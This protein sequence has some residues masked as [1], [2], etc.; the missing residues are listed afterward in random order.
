[1][2]M[3]VTRINH[4][5]AKKKTVEQLQAFME[6][7]VSKVQTLPGC[8]SVKLLRSTENPAHFAIVEEWDSIEDHQTAAASIPSDQ[9]KKAKSLVAKPPVGEYY[10]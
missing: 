4:F 1:M 2:N 8:R 5:E 10:Q 7:V 6:D 3:P 9:L